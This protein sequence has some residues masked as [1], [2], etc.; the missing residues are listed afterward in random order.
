MDG[1]NSS[2][3][4]VDWNEMKRPPASSDLV[5]S[6]PLKKI[7]KTTE[8]VNYEVDEQEDSQDL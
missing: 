4:Y 7:K 8:E 2:Q 1:L 6:A 3:T 5:V